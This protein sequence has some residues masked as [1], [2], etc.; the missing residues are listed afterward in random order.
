MP[1]VELVA[2]RAETA[3]ALMRAVM[4]VEKR[5]MAILVGRGGRL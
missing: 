3:M 4:M 2:G 5:I 1:D